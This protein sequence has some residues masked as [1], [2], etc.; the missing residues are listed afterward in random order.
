VD[1]EYVPLV[2]R[3]RFTLLTNIKETTNKAI[4]KIQPI[5][6]IRIRTKLIAVDDIWKKFNSKIGLIK[7][8]MVFDYDF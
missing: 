7:G 8:N 4:I 2:A 5:V 6:M 3:A 1:G